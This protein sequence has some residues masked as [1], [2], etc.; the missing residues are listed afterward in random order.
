MELNESCP[1][2]YC[3]FTIVENITSLCSACPKGYRTSERKI[4]EKCLEN[5]DA[6]SWLFVGF[7]AL[8]PVMLHWWQILRNKDNCSGRVTFL[9]FFLSCTEC[10]LSGILTLLFIEPRGRFEVHSCRVR[11]LSDWYT[12]FFNPQIRYETTIHCTQEAVYPL[13]SMIFIYFGFTLLFMILFRPIIL[14]NCFPK[15]QWKDPFYAA[16][17]FYPILIVVHAITGGLLYYSFPYLAILVSLGSIVTYFAANHVFHW[18]LIFNSNR[19]QHILAI[20]WHLLVSSYGIIA[21]SVFEFYFLFLAPLPVLIFFI[22]AR[23]TDPVNIANE[24]ES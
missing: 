21:I 24:T 7:M 22:T 11:Q 1:G 18:K 23:L 19:N 9:L 15:K 8:L 2:R 6:Y 14:Y 16:M 4:C 3:G 20:L 17:Y 13:S 10:I 12:M 5:P